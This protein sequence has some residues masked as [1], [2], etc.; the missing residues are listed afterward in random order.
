MVS[1]LEIK[2]ILRP[3]HLSGRITTLPSRSTS[4]SCSFLPLKVCFS[5][6]VFGVFVC[7]SGFHWTKCQKKISDLCHDAPT[8]WLRDFVCELSTYKLSNISDLWVFWL[9]PGIIFY[10]L[11]TVKTTK[12][13]TYLLVNWL[14]KPKV[15]KDTKEN[16]QHTPV[17]KDKNETRAVKTSSIQKGSLCWK[18]PQVDFVYCALDKKLPFKRC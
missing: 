9:H 6:S 3:K 1:I 2:C 15:S 10:Q 14:D 8:W 12:F 18:W 11:R 5:L 17:W 7:G 16:W 4:L 13:N